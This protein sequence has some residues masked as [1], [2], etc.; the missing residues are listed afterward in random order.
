MKSLIFLLFITFVSSELIPIIPKLADNNS[1]IGGK[2]EKGR[3]ICPNSTALIGYECKPCIGGKVILNRCRC[4]LGKYLSGNKCKI[5]RLFTT[6][7][8]TSK[9][10]HGWLNEKSQ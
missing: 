8:I 4:P 3:C 5:R 7:I 9:P 1:C 10:T 6:R 2:I